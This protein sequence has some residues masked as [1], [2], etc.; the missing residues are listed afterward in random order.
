MTPK[1]A[2]PRS[3]VLLLKQWDRYPRSTERISCCN[4]SRYNYRAW[5]GLHFLHPLT[6]FCGSLYLARRTPQIMREFDDV[7]APVNFRTSR[8]FGFNTSVLTVSLELLLSL[9]L[10]LSTAF[11][12][13][14][15]ISYSR[16][17]QKL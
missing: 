8:Q 2:W 13:C 10:P 7:F 3:R 6:A 15:K 9:H 17:G 14:C 5:S 4:Q 11:L 1:G 12:I 16:V